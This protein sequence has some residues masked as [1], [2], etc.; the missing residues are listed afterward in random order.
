MEDIS[1]KIIKKAINGDEEA[2]YKIVNHYSDLIFGLSLKRLENYHDAQDCTQEIIE[3]IVGHLSDFNVDGDANIGT[4]IYTIADNMLSNY[5]RK[6]GRYKS[7][8]I[9]NEEYV[10]NY[11]QEDEDID[12]VLFL[13]QLKNKLKED[14]YNVLY[15]KLG[16]GL[17]Y[18][19]IAELYSTKEY[20]IR[21]IYEEALREAQE[22]ITGVR[23]YEKKK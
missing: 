10:M 12:E 6:K 14:K 11:V 3:K 18:R 17:S 1:K 7:R 16:K 13:H 23:I 9:N 4:W 21:R 22:L 5:N 2:M 8:I 15:Y 19:E 20:K